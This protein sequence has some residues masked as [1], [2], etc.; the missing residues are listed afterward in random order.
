MTELSVLYGR[1]VLS[2]KES[3]IIGY[4]KSV[5]FENSCKRIA[6]FGMTP[7]FNIITSKN[8]DETKLFLI[9]FGD[10][11]SFND[12]LVVD[13][14][15]Y[16]HRFADVDTTDF[17]ED[18]V[19]KPI[20]TLTGKQ[21][22]DILAVTFDIH[23][24]VRAIK[25]KTKK[26]LPTDFYNIGDILLIRE[27]DG[28]VKH[29]PKK[30]FPIPTEDRVVK[31]LKTPIAVNLKDEIESIEEI[32]KDFESLNAK[33]NDKFDKDKAKF[34]KKL[35][36]S[37][38]DES[39]NLNSRPNTFNDEFEN[40]QPLE[41]NNFYN[42]DIGFDDFE[43]YDD[44]EQ[45]E[46]NTE[47]LVSK[48][49]VSKTLKA[50]TKKSNPK[51]EIADNDISQKKNTNQDTQIK[52]ND[53]TSKVLKE[54][55]EI[56]KNIDK[57]SVK[58]DLENKTNTSLNDDFNNAQNLIEESDTK[59]EIENSTN[60]NI[61]EQ[62]E[63]KKQK[64]PIIQPKISAKMKTSR[65]ET[66]TILKTEMP[67]VGEELVRNADN[68]PTI[69]MNKDDEREPVLTKDAFEKISG[70]DSN[71]I[72]Y[73]DEHTPTRII[74]EYDF[75]LDRKLIADLNTYSG[76]LI[77]KKGTII[78]NELV[79]TARQCGKLVELTLNSK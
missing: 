25:T 53:K 9:E 47:N 11:L 40:I 23:A 76:D 15:L 2:R 4:V 72:R 42:D 26:Y 31:I 30:E 51:S 57:K 13:S 74:C 8:N 58:T 69:V 24:K 37:K 39:K 67:L 61:V 73:E 70:I 35:E 6:Y 22:E 63:T 17:V 49:K 41:E 60:K 33:S 50:E 28:V 54:Q 19:G 68:S 1:P 78:T 46:I 48:E 52:K 38:D 62:S 55:T 79:E 36:N 34:V 71:S 66:S 7:A 75:L 20:F 77:A 5:Y 64:E 27:G 32:K 16:L 10:I 3:C 18:L 14:T 45:I 12:A 65:A 29:A 44:F 59:S 43:D 56:K 21:K